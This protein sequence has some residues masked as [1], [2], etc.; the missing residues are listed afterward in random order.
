MKD[1]VAQTKQGNW[2]NESQKA[3]AWVGLGCLPAAD[4]TT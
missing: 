4:H 1:S 3:R 2:K